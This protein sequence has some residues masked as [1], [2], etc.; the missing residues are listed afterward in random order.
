MKAGKISRR[1][2]GILAGAYTFLQRSFSP[3]WP[4]A[5]AL[6]RMAHR[7]ELL[8]LLAKHLVIPITSRR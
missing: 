6:A 7:E 3:D 4:L 2:S 1:A 8:G 5:I